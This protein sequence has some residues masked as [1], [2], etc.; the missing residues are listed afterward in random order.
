MTRIVRLKRTPKLVDGAKAKIVVPTEEQDQ[1]KL[2]VWVRKMGLPIVGS[3]AAGRRSIWE[4]AKLKRMGCV[5]GWPDLFMPVPNK[6]FPGLFIE[7]KRASG[8]VVSESQLHWLKILRQ[9]GYACE[10]CRGLEE[11]KKV[12]L[13]YLANTDEIA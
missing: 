5:S 10:I 9:N 1:I 2:V 12:I 13:D 8:G 4:G 3:P 7:L 6:T 11:A